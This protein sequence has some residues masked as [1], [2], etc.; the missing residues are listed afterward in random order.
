MRSVAGGFGHLGKGLLVPN[1]R[2][3]PC[4]FCDFRIACRRLH[5]PSAERVL[6]SPI[7]E[8]RR[9]LAL[10]GKSPSRPLLNAE[11]EG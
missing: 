8:V 3:G 2:H 11:E 4:A 9:Y 10:S 5:P 6:G 7:P 1:V